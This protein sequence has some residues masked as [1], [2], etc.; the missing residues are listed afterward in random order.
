MLRPTSCFSPALTAAE[1]A[2]AAMDEAALAAE[3]AALAV[4]DE[5]RSSPSSSPSRRV[6]VEVE[7][8]FVPEPVMD[9]RR[10]A[11]RVAVGS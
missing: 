1:V 7:V 4:V 10:A 11:G 2:A 5:R 8:G 3:V 6:E 9:A